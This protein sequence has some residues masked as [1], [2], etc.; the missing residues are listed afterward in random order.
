MKVSRYDRVTLYD[1]GPT[2]DNIADEVLSGLGQQ[3]KRLPCKLFYDER[4][5]QLFDEICTLP[6]YYPTRTEV[7][8]LSKYVG[9]MA[10]IIGPRCRLLELGSGSSLKTRILLDR[11]DDLS[12]YVPIDISRSQLLDSA[13]ALANEH[14]RLPV[15]AVC[16]DYTQDFQLPEA[17]EP[18][19]RTVAFFPGSTIGNLEPD[20]ARR[21]L[22]RIAAWCGRG[23]GL[24]IG[25]DVKKDRAIV[26]AAYNDRQ[27]VTADFNLNLL[28]RINRELDANFERQAF[29]HRA[30]YDD[31][32]GRI[33]MQLVS[34]R[35]Q[36][37]H[38]QGNEIAFAE[39]EWITTEYS[40]KYD[41][42]EFRAL[43]ADSGFDVA[44]VWT[45]D[46][47]LFSVQYLSVAAA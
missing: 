40:Y 15:L 37:V 17:P 22:R 12:A 11:L 3:A 14:P 46:D 29:R 23:G 36:A 19:R 5:S 42:E 34:R 16:V 26:E 8:I 43:A 4:G 35:P 38:L 7:S 44:H 33:E 28:D 10:D 6:E 9:D 27:G 18:A 25:V 2:V 45:D 47:R 30:I 39:G 20:E 13:L 21:F 31:S 24:L 1:Y 32:A 41:V